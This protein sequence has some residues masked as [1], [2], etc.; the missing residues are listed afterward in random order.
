MQLYDVG[1]TSMFVQ[2]AFAL[3]ELAQLIGQPKSL[4]DMLTKRGTDMAQ[5]ISEHLWNEQL[6]I[7]VNRFSADHANGSFYPHMSP[8]SFYALQAK[9]A[10]DAQATRMAEGW[11]M[12]RSRFCV[13]PNG[14]YQGNDDTCY[15][16]LPSIEASDPAYPALGYWVSTHTHVWACG[17]S[18]LSRVHRDCVR[19]GSCCY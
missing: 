16:G 10:T 13:A 12:N 5:K 8:T 2:E 11:L 1:M 17:G 18:G 7:F 14:D 6:G 15:W 3:A 4:S 19:V 9:A